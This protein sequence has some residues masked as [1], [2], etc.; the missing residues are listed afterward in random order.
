MPSASGGLRPDP[1]TMGSGPPYRLAL[2]ARH[3]LS[4][5]VL[6]LTGNQPWLSV[7]EWPAEMCPLGGPHIPVT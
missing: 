7:L 3:I 1:P 4:V 6:L 2:R 5:P